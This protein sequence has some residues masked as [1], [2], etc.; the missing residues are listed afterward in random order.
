VTGKLTDAF[1][2]DF[3][4]RVIYKGDV[5][6]VLETGPSGDPK[7]QR[8]LMDLPIVLVRS[9]ALYLG[10]TVPPVPGTVNYVI[11]RKPAFPV[12]DLES[13]TF[14]S[15]VAQMANTRLVQGSVRI[16]AKR[17]DGADVVEG[18][19]YSV[20]YELGRIRRLTTWQD[21]VHFKANYEWRQE[22][23][24]YAG[25]VSGSAPRFY[26]GTLTGATTVRVTQLAFWAPDTL[27]DRYVLSNNFG[28]LIGRTGPSSESYR[29]FLLGIFQLYVLGPVM[30][31]IESAMN[32]ICG[33]PVV[34]DDGEVLL[35]VVTTGPDTNIVR[36]TRAG[37]TV[38]EYAF[39]KQTPLRADVTTT[40]NWGSLIFRSF[41][42][43][44][45][46]VRVTD[47]I[48]DP[49]WWHNIVIPKELFASTD[50]AEVPDA[51][52]RTVSDRHVLHRIGAE[53]APR[54]GDPGLYIGADDDG[55]I[56]PA[57]H[58]LLR[59]R[60]AFVMMDRFFKAHMF[61]VGFDPSLFSTTGQGAKFT[62]I[63]DDLND[64]ILSAKPSHTYIYVEPSTTFKDT[65][66]MYD[67]GY[68][69]PQD[70]EGADPDAQ[71]V[72]DDP[73]E[74]PSNTAPYVQLGLSILAKFITTDQFLITDRA[75]LIGDTNL[76]IGDWFTYEDWTSSTTFPDLTTAVTL[77][78]GPSAPTRA[79]LVA[80]DVLATRSGRRLVENVDYVVN[81]TARTVRALTTWDSMTSVDVHFLQALLLNA[82]DGAPS[83]SNGQ[84]PLMVDGIDP[85]L[86]RADY[87]ST[88]VDLFDN[89]WPVT[90]HRDM[91]MV[92]RPLTI[93]ITEV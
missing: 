36:T 59:R 2:T 74:L 32:V 39:P 68:Y 72:Y 90:D 23:F 21:N 88:A 11:L 58:P 13:G 30:A 46:V 60:F 19:D 10:G 6:R 69:Q 77:P 31:R 38:V 54:I 79:L 53:D 52:R 18:T 45:T 20:D 34:R 62:R 7:P 67:A 50:G 41:E 91:S 71:Q 35:D 27:V 25:A 42:P 76:R 93:K 47:Y 28:S 86:V 17:L 8:A 56:P 80:V 24:P 92:E 1:D 55:I 65:M 16:Y 82:T 61:F 87:D 70:Y 73:S 26:T 83:M 22:V 14:V 85:T 66:V 9:D 12:V 51:S 57:G 33:L 37:G 44:T 48:E 75:P 40:S 78:H 89:P 4:S 5:L 49:S 15:S 29:A 81:Y 63:V 43:L 84:M 3:V 64:L